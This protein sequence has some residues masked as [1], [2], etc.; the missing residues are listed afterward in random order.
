MP[1]TI[2]SPQTA[3]RERQAELI[4]HH[5]GRQPA[6][7]IDLIQEITEL[8]RR[9]MDR[10]AFSLPVM[11]PLPRSAYSASEPVVK[12]LRKSTASFTLTTYAVV[13]P[14]EVIDERHWCTPDCNDK[15]MQLAEQIT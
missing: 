3:P 8:P 14:R 11:F 4:V 10:L 12:K 7:A 6:R 13:C 5:L 15:L 2:R 1:V 9:A